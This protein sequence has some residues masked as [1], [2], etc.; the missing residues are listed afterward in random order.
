M[1]N[2]VNMFKR[3]LPG[4]ALVHCSTVGVEQDLVKSPVSQPHSIQVCNTATDVNHIGP[5]DT[6]LAEHYAG[7]EVISDQVNVYDRV[8]PGTAHAYCSRVDEAKS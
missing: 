8:I 3:E 7:D 5:T 2:Q 6:S 4:S 1:I